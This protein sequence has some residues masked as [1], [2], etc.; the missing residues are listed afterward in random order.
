MK[1]ITEVFGY[2]DMSTVQSRSLP[3][4]LK[5]TDVLVKAK[6]GTGKT[7]SFLIP[8]VELLQKKQDPGHVTALIITPIRELAQQTFDEL[9]KLTQFSPN[10]KTKT[11][12]GG[13]KIGKDLSS[14]K[15]NVPDI[16][17]A[18][19]GR[20]R[21]ILEDPQFANLLD[22]VKIL[23]FDEA[24]NL[25]NMGFK[26]AIDFIL[27]YCPGTKARQTLLFSATLPASVIELGKKNLKAQHENMDLV[28]KEE[29]TH[30]HVPQTCVVCPQA[31]FFPEVFHGVRNG[32]KE[33]PENFKIIV[34]SPIARGAQLTAEIARHALPGVQVLEI[35]SRL[36][37]SERKKSSDAFRTGTKVVMFT[38]DVSARGLDY[39]DVTLVIQAG[40]P[41]DK[42][43]YIHRL[44]RTARAGKQGSG[45]LILADYEKPFL[46][47]LSDLPIEM[48]PVTTPENLKYLNLDDSIRALNKTSVAQYYAAALGYYRSQ[49]SF[50]ADTKSL[51]ATQNE[52]A[53]QVLFFGEQPPGIQK[54]TIGKMGLKGVP[55]IV[56]EED[57]PMEQRQ[58]RQ[59]KP[60]ANAEAQKKGGPPHGQ[61][62]KEKPVQMRGRAQQNK[63]RRQNQRRASDE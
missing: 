33:F 12:F 6:T 23:V 40:A 8:I 60:R 55:G 34:F 5:G 48:K 36:S 31:S 3:V 9:T 42:E 51:V 14:L 18:T 29:P 25:L 43:Q 32:M 2:A 16:L 52:M 56:I 27:Q 59:Q 50:Y 4:T 46:K 21:T 57:E 17:V 45:F 63:S 38:S 11:L 13:G 47:K 49:P 37:Q 39:P 19:P 26:P 41:S 10:I 1:S 28:G 24:D 20:L 58:Q 7:L 22:N 15:K 62:E 54:R 61:K 35:H 30:L 53:C 44:G